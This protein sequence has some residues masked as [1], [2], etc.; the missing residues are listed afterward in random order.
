MRALY[1][2]SIVRRCSDGAGWTMR[3]RSACEWDCIST[4]DGYCGTV[5][6]SWL[7]ICNL[8]FDNGRFDKWLDTRTW[9]S[10]RNKLILLQT[11]TR[12]KKTTTIELIT[13]CMIFVRPLRVCGRWSKIARIILMEHIFIITSK[14]V[15]KPTYDDF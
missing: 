14:N 12:K 13:L 8:R 6:H 7:C 1:Y 5:K 9:S 10:S 11:T 15:I 3:R 2:M 4:R